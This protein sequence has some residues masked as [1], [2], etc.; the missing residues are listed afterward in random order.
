MVCCLLKCHGH[1][2][3]YPCHCYHDYLFSGRENKVGTGHIRTGSSQTDQT[4]EK[5]YEP[6]AGGEPH[7]DEDGG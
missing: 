6:L 4:E 1:L 5:S 7:S 3:I 2:I